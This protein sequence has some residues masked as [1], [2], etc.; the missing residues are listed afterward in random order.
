MLAIPLPLPLLF[1]DTH[2]QYNLSDVKSCASSSAF[3]S[4]G[5]FVLVIP[6]SSLRMALTI[7][8]EDNPA[9]YSFDEISIEEFV[10]EKFFHSTGV[11]SYFYLT[12]ACLMMSAFNFPK[13]F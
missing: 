11:F 12:S 2:S 6:L 8:L 4:S 1:L 3:L 13:Y 9:L 5:P 10:F 7:S